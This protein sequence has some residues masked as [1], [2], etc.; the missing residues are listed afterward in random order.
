M[1]ENKFLRLQKG[2]FRRGQVTHSNPEFESMRN[3]DCDCDWIMID[4]VVIRFQQKGDF[5]C[6]KW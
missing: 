1:G 3:I 5:G 2:K 6:R 4:L